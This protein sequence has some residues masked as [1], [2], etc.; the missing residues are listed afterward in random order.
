M[1]LVVGLPFQLQPQSLDP[2]Y[3]FCARGMPTYEHLQI[4]V[5]FRLHIFLAL[6]MALSILLSHICFL[7]VY[8]VLLDAISF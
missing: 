7:L 8:D 6:S 5:V 3:G 1:F 2:V 4:Y